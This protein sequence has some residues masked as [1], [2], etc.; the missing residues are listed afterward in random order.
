MFSALNTLIPRFFSNA[1]SRL[2]NNKPEQMLSKPITR[3][4]AG[5]GTSG[6]HRIL[7][8]FLG[9]KTSTC[10]KNRR[11][12]ILQ[13]RNSATPHKYS[14]LSAS[15]FHSCLYFSLCISNCS[16]DGI[17]NKLA[18]S[19]D[20]LFSAPLTTCFVSVPRIVHSQKEISLSIITS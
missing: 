20:F 4:R 13:K 10:N 9:Y 15:V 5:V 19:I 8:Y 17:T 3:E 14:S 16:Y 2:F 6:L 7:T 11:F 12:A 1:I 18:S